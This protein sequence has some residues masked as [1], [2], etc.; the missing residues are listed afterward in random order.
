MASGS[1]TLLLSS[2]GVMFESNLDACRQSLL[3]QTLLS[4]DGPSSP[5]YLEE[6]PARELGRV[7]P[8][9]HYSSILFN[10]FYVFVRYWTVWRC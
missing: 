8:D 2:H 5:I 1:P 7:S 4:C 10:H 3:V 6:I 9:G